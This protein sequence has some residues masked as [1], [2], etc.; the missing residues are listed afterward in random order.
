MTIKKKWNH[1]LVYNWNVGWITCLKGL[2]PSK[3]MDWLN[4]IFE[5]MSVTRFEQW[6]CIF[7]VLSRH[8]GYL[9]INP[10]TKKPDAKKKKTDGFLPKK[11]LKDP[12][13]FQQNPSVFMS[14]VWDMR[15]KL[16]EKLFY[17]LE[18]KF[19]PGLLG[20]AFNG[21]LRRLWWFRHRRSASMGHRCW[22][23]L[24][25]SFFWKHKLSKFTAGEFSNENQRRIFSYSYSTN[26]VLDWMDGF[27]PWNIKWM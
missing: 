25:R 3:W 27:K 6:N 15:E 11:K 20:C 21:R 23:S 7:E 24:F 9:K 8:L 26:I 16:R 5:K 12:E 19:L 22:M 2:G 18:V 14:Q 10:Q 13:N 17:I 4:H 1:H